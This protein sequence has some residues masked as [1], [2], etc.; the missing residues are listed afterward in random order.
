[1]ARSSYDVSDATADGLAWSGIGQYTD[2]ANPM[3]MAILMGAIANGGTPVMPYFV[4]SVTTSF[5][6][7]TE[8]GSAVLGEEMMSSS[9]AQR[10][11]EYMRNNVSSYYGDGMFPGMEVCAKTGTAEVGGGKQPTGWIVGFSANSATPYAFAVVVEE[12]SS[13]IGSAGSVASTVMGALAS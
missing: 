8:T 13:G 10:L 2:L 7:V 1:M 12:G 3:H 6:L 5:G 11:Q 4:Q 9:T